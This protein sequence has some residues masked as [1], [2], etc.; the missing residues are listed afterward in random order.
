[1]RAA[2]CAAALKWLLFG[3]KGSIIRKI[4]FMEDALDA[5]KL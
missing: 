2:S 4:Q 1:M 3:E 5:G